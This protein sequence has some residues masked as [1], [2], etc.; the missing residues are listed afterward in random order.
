MLI[1]SSL[2]QKIQIN[3]NEDFLVEF[4]CR[5]MG[6]DNGMDTLYHMDQNLHRALKH[7]S[8]T[9]HQPRKPK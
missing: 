7:M 3:K 5:R 9:L 4:S 8:E 6:S 1:D 2:P